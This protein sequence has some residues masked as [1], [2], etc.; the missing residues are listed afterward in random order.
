[1]NFSGRPTMVAGGGLNMTME[2]IGGKELLAAL[3]SLP[4]AVMRKVERQGLKQAAEMVRDRAKQ[5]CPVG[6]GI[7]ALGENIQILAESKGGRLTKEIP[8]LLRD[9]IKIIP[10]K[11]KKGFISRI[12]GTAEGWFKG[13]TFYGGIVEFGGTNRNYPARPFIRPAFDSQREWLLARI[14]E[15]INTALTKVWMSKSGKE[16]A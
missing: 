4:E 14:I 6:K 12:I 15:S 8:G 1:M 2:V 5:L 3:N 7:L 16:A 11:R 13:Q 9:S 10:G